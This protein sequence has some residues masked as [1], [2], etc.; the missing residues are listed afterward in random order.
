M[1]D[2]NHSANPWDH[3]PTWFVGFMDDVKAQFRGLFLLVDRV[4]V[5]EQRVD[6]H[7]RALSRVGDQVDRHEDRLDHLSVDQ[8]SA[9]ERGRTNTDAR[10]HVE[11]AISAAIGGI[12]VLVVQY[13]ASAL[14]VG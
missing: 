5:L 12:V 6:E 3:P 14:G 7:S 1:P 4:T 9:T 13:G 2:D 11:R 10:Q 8:A